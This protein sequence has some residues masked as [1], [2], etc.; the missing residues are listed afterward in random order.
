M[1]NKTHRPTGYVLYENANIVA[2]ATLE[3]ENPKTGNMVQICLLPRDIDPATAVKTGQDDIVCFD[4]PARGEYCY[5]NVWQAPLS[6]WRA[7]QRGNYPVLSSDGYRAV[8]AGRKIRFG[9]YG[10]PI[11]LP[12]LMV[13][14]LAEVSD[15]WTGYTHQWRRPEYRAYRHYF[16]AS[17]ETAE[18][19][20]QA[21]RAGWRT[22]RVRTADQPL[23]AHE[24]ACPA[25][26]EMQHRTT[27]ENCRL[28]DGSTG[29]NDA[30]KDIAIIVHGRGS[31]NFV[32]LGAL[33]APVK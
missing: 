4:C 11:L 26:D 24:I 19:Y 32:S 20:M 1:T 3:T 31:K 28:C 13:A 30:R 15:G 12:L 27:C 14:Q 6:V 2:I 18:D 25:S 23:M 7:Y 16:M 29:A 9:A 5:V 33:M 17:C 10:E 21:I 22:F 8:F